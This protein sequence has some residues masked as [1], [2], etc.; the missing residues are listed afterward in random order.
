MKWCIAGLLATLA[1][2]A[3]G[4]KNEPA[5]EPVNHKNGKVVVI[6]EDCPIQTS[7]NIFNS[8]LS[9]IGDRTITFVDEN[10]DRVDFDPRQMGRDTLEIP[11]FLGYAEMQHM[12]QVLEYDYYH[13]LLPHPAAAVPHSL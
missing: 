7:T 11:T 1:L 2:C 9:H 8:S 13:D 10:G 4:P 3:C 5:A 12:Y 6:F